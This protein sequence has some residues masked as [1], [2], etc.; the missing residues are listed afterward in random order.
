MSGEVWFM[1]GVALLSL[2]GLV[3]VLRMPPA[4]PDEEPAS[5]D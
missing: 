3:L 5:H 2:A 1:V 4:P